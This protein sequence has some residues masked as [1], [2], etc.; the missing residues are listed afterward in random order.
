MTEDFLRRQIA[1]FLEH[2]R[3]AKIEDSNAREQ[4]ADR[5]TEHLTRNWLQA[6]YAREQL[7]KRRR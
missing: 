2:D 6:E 3:M 4:A 7:D 5:L 1:V